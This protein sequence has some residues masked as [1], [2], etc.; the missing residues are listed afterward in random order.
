MKI[1][2]TSFTGGIAGA[3]HSIAYLAKGLAAKGHDIYLAGVADNLL[4]QLVKDTPVRFVPMP[5]RSKVDRLTIRLI[6]D[7][8]RREQIDIINAQNSKDRYLTIFARW[9]FKLPVKVVHTRRQRPE[10]IGGW[11]QNTFY[12]RG[13]DGIVVISDELKKIFVEKGMPPHHLHVIYNG[14]PLHQYAQVGPERVAQL[15]AQYGLRPED[16]VIGCVARMKRQEELIRALAD[17]DDRVKV[18][19][20]GIAP[21]SLDRYVAQYHIKNP[22]IYAG[23]LSHADALH[24]Y[25]LMD[26]SVLPSDM[27]G[28]GL[29]LVEAMALG[30]P[31]VATRAGGIVNVVEDGVSG[32]LYA[33][34]Q[35][36]DLAAKLN[37]VLQ[38]PELRAQL[39][40]NGRDTALRKFSLEK[41][42]DR[43]EAYFQSLLEK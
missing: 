28:F 11:V 10:S 1:L 41:T 24:L 2:F 13:T 37:A 4:H 30:T 23:M 42:I 17:V 25:K 32:L 18:I 31:V 9:L 26:V 38:Q 7:L 12:V 39:I 16:T 33:C 40:R 34:G 15:R 22:I 21:G 27:D 6:A 5:F 35:P 29:V 20:A 14:T 8:V 36:A 3:T 19:F 43:Y